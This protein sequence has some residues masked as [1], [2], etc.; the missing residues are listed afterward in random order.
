MAMKLHS[1]PSES[2]GFSTASKLLK[3]IHSRDTKNK[4]SKRS[5]ADVKA[6]LETQDSFTLHRPVRKR[7]SRNPYVVT[8]L[9]DVGKTIY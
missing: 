7:F 8:N 2:A 4:P 5:L 3:A 1:D 6:W 9:M